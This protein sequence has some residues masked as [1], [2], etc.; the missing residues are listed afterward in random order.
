VLESRWHLVTINRAALIIPNYTV[1]ISRFLRREI[2]MQLIQCQ[3]T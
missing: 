3:Y 1:T 2:F